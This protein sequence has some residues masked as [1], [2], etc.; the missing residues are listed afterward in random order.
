MGTNSDIF[1]AQLA[2]I[3]AQLEGHEFVLVDGQIECEPAEGS[4]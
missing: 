3:C 1:E 4:P 2:P